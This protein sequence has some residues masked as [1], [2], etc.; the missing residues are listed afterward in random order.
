ML[1]QWNFSIPCAEFNYFYRK[2]CYRQGFRDK[3][4]MPITRVSSQWKIKTLYPTKF[5]A[6]RHYIREFQRFHEDHTRRINR[7]GEFTANGSRIRQRETSLFTRCTLS[8]I[9]QLVVAKA[10]IIN[11]SNFGT[12]P[13]RLTSQS[14]YG[15]RQGR[16][17]GPWKRSSQLPRTRTL[18]IPS[19]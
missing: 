11:Q 8:F 9:S 15:D 13:F 16:Y 18:R 2:T 17:G 3:G 5:Q 4:A 7:L 14:I 1:I 10:R 19:V 12:L 6:V